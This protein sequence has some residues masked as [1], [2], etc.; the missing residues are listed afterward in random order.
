MAQWIQMIFCYSH[1][2][3][4]L[5][6]NDLELIK[7]EDVCKVGEGKRRRREERRKEE[8]RGEKRRGE[9]RTG[10]RKEKE[11]LLTP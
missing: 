7:S 2:K 3:L 11:R 8:K 10:V 9:M 6:E 5:T 1:Q 4:I